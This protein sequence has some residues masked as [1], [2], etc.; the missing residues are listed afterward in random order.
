L[1]ARR[2]AC[3]L[4][5]LVAVALA[6]LALGAP[7]FTWANQGVRLEH[8]RA[9]G[10][11]ALGAALAL[12]A[13]AYGARRRALLVG[14]GL[15]VLALVS[16]GAHRLAWRIDAIEAGLHERSLAGSVRLGWSEVTA[17]EPRPDALTLRARDGRT[18][19]IGTRAVAPDERVRLERTI[20]R[21]VREAAR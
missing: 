19:V 3:L 13:A 14:A 21:R 7:R 17:V 5:L 1:T 18:V 2:A 4:L 20:A 11:A 8:P 6:T 12:G 15:G 10:I 9:H 16:V